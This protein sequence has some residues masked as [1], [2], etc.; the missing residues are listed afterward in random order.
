MKK[1]RINLKKLNWHVFKNL[2]PEQ[3]RI[4]IPNVLTSI[5][6]IL[7]GCI[8]LAMVFGWW[9]TAFFLFLIAAITDVADGTIARLWN[10]KTFLGA[11][12]DPI[13]DKLL[14]ISIFATLAFVET[15][16]IA[17]PRWF[18][19]LIVIKEL[20]QVSGATILYMINGHLDVRPTFLGKMTTFV[21][22]IFI[23]WLFACYYFDWMP[24]K[25]Y[26]AMLVLML[27]MVFASLLQYAK[28][29]KRYM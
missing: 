29:G 28:I 20:L 24:I 17:L 23:I 7:V 5:R 11:C 10:V 19:L 14:I 9:N 6:I 22:T 26:Y 21:Q 3:K 13:A 15:P 12:L 4:T 16:L 27:A 2:P 18:V 25:T 1:I 8:V